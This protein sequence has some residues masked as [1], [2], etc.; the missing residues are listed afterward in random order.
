M[1]A[2][3]THYAPYYN[4]SAKNS[5][6]SQVSSLITH[7]SPTV[8]AYTLYITLFNQPPLPSAPQVYTLRDPYYSSNS[9]SQTRPW[10]GWET[11]CEAKDGNRA[12]T[13]CEFEAR[14]SPPPAPTPMSPSAPSASENVRP[15]RLR[16]SWGASASARGESSGG[17][18]RGSTDSASSSGEGF[19][20]GFGP[21]PGGSG[22]FVA[23]S[24]LQ[25]ASMWSTAVEQAALER[26]M[27]QAS[28]V[29][30]M[31]SP[32]FVKGT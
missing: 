1:S 15:R 32:R 23:P 26:R 13:G 4:S 24:K 3:P 21:G 10:G 30:P 8:K 16:Q 27:R 17:S 5:D 25:E 12:D 6:P 2:Q 28:M 18:R 22:A 14:R 19:G 31:I 29:G 11:D 7:P 9:S 20:G